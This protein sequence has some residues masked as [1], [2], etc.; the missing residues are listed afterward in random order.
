MTVPS[1]DDRR[2]PVLH[3][4]F[5]PTMTIPDLVQHFRDMERQM[6]RRLPFACVVDAS[7]VVPS[8]FTAVHRRVTAAEL[9]RLAPKARGYLRRQCFVTS[10]V[11]ARGVLTAVFW[12]SSPPIPTEV[13]ASL[14]E[15]R[16]WAGSGLAGA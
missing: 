4:N 2:W 12:L 15:A 11:L 9:A 5:P 13:F 6:D 14:L 7:A 1:L 8:E 3:V 10:S 16:A